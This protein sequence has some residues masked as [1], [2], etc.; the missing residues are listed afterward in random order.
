MEAA[1]VTGAAGFIGSHLTESLLDDG[2]RVI[3]VDNLQTGREANLASF[4]DHS[5]FTFAQADIRDAARMH[6]LATGVDCVFHHA[7]IAS[8]PKSIHDPVETTRTN[9]LGTTVVLEAA[10]RTGVDRVVVASSAAVYGE[11][12]SLPM[13]ESMPVA[14]ASPYAL[15]KYYTE[16][17]AVQYTDLI[18]LDTVAL[19][20]FNVFGP[21]Q[22]PE[23]EYAAVIPAFITRML[24]GKPPVVYG[25]GEQSRDFVHVDNVVH[26]NRRAATYS[27]A[28]EVFNIASGQRV[29]INELVDTLNGLLDTT[30]NPVYEAPRP[31]E[32]RHATAD[33]TNARA[34]L[35]FA[36]TVDFETGLRDT[37]DHYHD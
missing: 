11:P 9:C 8:V 21:R 28:G 33:T 35:E 34:R 24:D 2:V 12:E 23:S 17:L 18:G 36:P 3:G 32:I 22:D 29:S 30:Y 26:A 16:R 4:R 20:Y 27:G 37:I 6:D 13:T 1:L 25:D 5:A 10:R 15:S 19:R 7:A 14:P 31:G